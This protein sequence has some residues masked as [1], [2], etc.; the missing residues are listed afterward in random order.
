M[1][2]P[3]NVTDNV[4][5]VAAAHINSI[6]AAIQTWQGTVNA[7]GQQLNNCRRISFGA[8]AAADEI[9]LYE[10]GG[11]AVMLGFTAGQLRYSA[12]AGG[13]HSFYTANFERIRITAAGTT[14]FL[15]LNAAATV[16]GQ[17]VIAH[18]T[19]GTNAFVV[20]NFGSVL[21]IFYNGASPTFNLD[22]SNRIILA[23]PTAAAGLPSG[24]LWNDA[25]AVKIVP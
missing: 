22:T 10:S 3:P 9:V 2:W 15:P 14:Q 24:T 12:G 7:N 23:L 4:D 17:I 20:D 8:V 5:V 16:G 11:D 6:V 21:R 13:V 25:G 1:A 18:H 19:G